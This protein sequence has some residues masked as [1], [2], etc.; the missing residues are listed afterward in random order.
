VERH[1]FVPARL[2][3]LAYLNRPLPI[4]YGQTVSQPFIVALMTELMGVKIGAH[5]TYRH[6]ARAIC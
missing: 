3:A 1:R 6:G 4:D 2:A 5:Q